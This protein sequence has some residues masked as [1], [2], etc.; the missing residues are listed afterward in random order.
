MKTTKLSVAL[1]TLLLIGS[2]AGCRGTV[3]KSPDIGDSLS[4]ALSQAG[5]KDVTVSQD[6]DKGIVTLGGRV[7][8]EGE[9]AQAEAMANS[10]AA[11]QVV[12]VG[13]GYG[14]HD[15]VEAVVPLT[16]LVVD[17]SYL[18]IVLHIALHE[19]RRSAALAG[20]FGDVALVALDM[21]EDQ[22]SP[23][24]VGLSGNGPGYAAMI[25]DAVDN[26]HLAVQPTHQVVPFTS[27]CLSDLRLRSHGSPTRCGGS[28]GMRVYSPST[29]HQDPFLPNSLRSTIWRIPPCR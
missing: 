20:Q 7:A 28:R 29:V 10:L 19:Q 6:R 17:G 5:L 4:K 18:G 26:P 15:E 3:P 16:H 25:G 14:M 2:I 9:K 13:E 8:S 27:L 12:A 1:S 23:L 24:R 22:G 21:V 11:G